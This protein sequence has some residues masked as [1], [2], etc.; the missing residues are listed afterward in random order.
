MSIANMVIVGFPVPVRCA[1]IGRSVNLQGGQR[2]VLYDSRLSLDNLECH[3]H[4][5]GKE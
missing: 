4:T 1:G 5:G 3:S 2:E